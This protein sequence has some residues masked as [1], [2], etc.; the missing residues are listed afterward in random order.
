MQT[1]RERNGEPPAGR[2]PELEE[3]ADLPSTLRLADYLEALW[4][5]KGLLLG[6][7]LLA[8]LAAAFLTAGMPN[9]YRSQA[10]LMVSAPREAVDASRV[11][12]LTRGQAPFSPAESAMAVLQSRDLMERVV[13]RLGPEAILG[14]LSPSAEADAQVRGLKG[15]LLPLLR[16]F[17]RGAAGCG[18][19]SEPDPVKALAALRK[20]LTIYG[21]QNSPAIQVLCRAGSADRAQAILQAFVEEGLRFYIELRSSESDRLFVEE[22]RARCVE[23]ARAAQEAY[24]AFLAEHRITDFRGELAG[25]MALYAELDRAIGR[26]RLELGALGPRVRQLQEKLR[27]YEPFLTQPT[28]EVALPNP[29]LARLEE[30]ILQREVELQEL[31]TRSTEAGTPQIRDKEQQIAFLR[32]RLKAERAQPG[33]VQRTTATLPNPEYERR[34]GAL[35]DMELQLQD[36]E[37]SLPERIKARDEL[38]GTI[39]ALQALEQH[40]QELSGA[41]TR[42][43]EQKALIESQLRGFLLSKE[44]D[45]RGLSNLQLIES[46]SLEPSK[47]GP[48]REKFILAGFL[49]AFAVLCPL[50]MLGLRI[51]TRLR[52]ARQI[53][54][55]L[56]VPVPAALPCLD[57]TN[58]RRYVKAR[59]KGWI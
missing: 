38:L 53:E 28:L 9:V 47:E 40:W 6:T 8:A 39:H 57:R 30:Q 13:A 41:A 5:R 12:G 27:A 23:E 52:R 50:I 7:S 44:L 31:K 34:R 15:L 25:R 10:R 55:L 17:Q 54:E 29:A 49:G 48:A 56:G 36:L 22:Q 4:R 42:A 18:T 14:P 35:L 33:E 46:P 43:E 24:R 45:A 20:S 21:D 11:L 26:D 3:A 32:E 51:S 59:D 16:L 37:S 1:R 19:E 2:T 58:I